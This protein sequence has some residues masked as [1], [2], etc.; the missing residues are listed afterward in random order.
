MF[1]QY[2]KHMGVKDILNWSSAEERSQEARTLTP[3]LEQMLKVQERKAGEGEFKS[4]LQRKY[5][6][7]NDPEEHSPFYQKEHQPYN[8]ITNPIVYRYKNPVVLK[9]LINQ[10]WREYL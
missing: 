6:M 2:N 5:F 4:D 9:K 1:Q 3:R 8:P 10:V 7:K